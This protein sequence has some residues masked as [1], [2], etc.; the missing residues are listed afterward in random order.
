V[1]SPHYGIL[2]GAQK[3]AVRLL[4]LDLRGSVGFVSAYQRL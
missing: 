4:Q 2:N 3:L 1:P